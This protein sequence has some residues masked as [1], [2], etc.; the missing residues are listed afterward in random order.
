MGDLGL[1]VAPLPCAHGGL[2][3]GTDAGEQRPLLRLLATIGGADLAVGRLYEGHVNALI[4]ISSFGSPEQI[5]RAARD[6][7]SGKIFGVWNTGVP[8]LLQMEGGPDVFYFRGR[9]S[10][11]SGAAFVERPIVTAELPGKGGWQMTLPRMESPEVARAVSIDRKFWQP[12]GMEAS[13]SFGVDFTGASV[14][15]EDLIG[16]PGDFYRDPLFRGG[17]IRFAAVQAGAVLRLHRLFAEWLERGGRGSDPYQVA[18]LGEIAVGAQEAVLWIE[19][20]AVVAEQGLLPQADKLASERMLE[21]ANMMRV[22]IERIATAVMPRVISGVGAHGLLQ[23]HPFERILRDLTMYL[24]QPAPDHALAEVGRASLRKTHLRGDGATNGF[25]TEVEAHAS[26]PPTYF[27]NIYARSDD[28]W[29]FRTSEYEDAKYGVTLDSLPRERYEK[30]VEIGCSIGVLTERL[31]SR[32]DDLLG[33]DVSERALE[34]ARQRCAHLRQV[35]FACM[36]VPH[37]IPEGLF[38]LI[39]LSEVAYYWTRKD[40]ERAATLLA[41]R[42]EQGGHLVLVHYTPFVPDYPLTGDQVHDFWCARSE[43]K[44]VRHSRYELYRVDVLER[45]V[46]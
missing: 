5:A 13:E 12:L 42:Q 31:A 2:G 35:H 10:F 1:L 18:R 22:A 30:V 27:Q 40:L 25:W 14:T 7:A 34:Q 21:C 20:A 39:L 11:A 43:W 32:C 45:R 23:P 26:L 15:R 24:R 38:D 29:S 37:E 33:L 19:R 41:A 16:G 9:K 3:L 44:V 36:E 6:A 8:D 4:L 17:A 46:N 28:P